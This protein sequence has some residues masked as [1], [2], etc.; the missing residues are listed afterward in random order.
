MPSTIGKCKLF[1]IKHITL[2]EGETFLKNKHEIACFEMKS[3]HFMVEKKTPLVVVALFNDSV[4]ILV[5]VCDSYLFCG[6][7][8][9]VRNQQQ[10]HMCC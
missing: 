8:V 9:Y 6:A 2:L 5:F 7:C 4:S 10:H 3:A 1:G